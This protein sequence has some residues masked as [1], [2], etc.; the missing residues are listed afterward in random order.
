MEALNSVNINEGTEMVKKVLQLMAVIGEDEISH[1]LTTVYH[2]CL[3]LK[4][5]KRRLNTKQTI[6]R[7][8]LF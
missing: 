1:M 4:S 7:E 3:D 8:G 6:L 5:E 2:T